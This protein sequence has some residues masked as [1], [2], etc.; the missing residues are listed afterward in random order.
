MSDIDLQNRPMDTP[1]LAK[2]TG[3]DKTTTV[4]PSWPPPPRPRKKRSKL[5]LA[6]SI[7]VIIISSLLLISSLALILFKTSTG[8][9]ASLRHAATVEVQQTR[10]VQNTAQAQAQGTANYFQTAQA[11]I[12]AS[13]TAEGNQAAIATQTVNDAT[14]TATAGEKLYQLWTA[15]KTLIDDPMQDNSGSS[16]WDRGGPAANTGCSFTDNTYHA[17]EAQI[18]YLQPCIAQ[19]T[20]ETDIAYQASVSILQGNPGEAGL[21]LRANSEGSSYYFFH[22]GSNGSYALDLYQSDNQGKI[23]LQGLSDAIT[24]G[25]Q[26]TNQL[27]ILAHQDSL[28]ILANGHYLGAISDDTLTSGKIG[29]AVINNGTPID[30]TFSDV[31]VWKNEIKS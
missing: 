3:G 26:Q 6:S 29:V 28:T 18:G 9:Q 16:K 1:A 19:G 25:L 17:K 31:K 8:Y 4:R 23:L 5:K 2:Q 27:M 15:S 21:L 13:A 24:P 12:E 11:Q 7:L 22:V 14:A 30:A 20:N 10:S